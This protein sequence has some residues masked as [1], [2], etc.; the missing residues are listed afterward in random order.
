MIAGLGRWAETAGGAATLINLS[1][2]HTFRIDLPRGDRYILR[3]HRPGYQSPAAIDSELAWLAALR[4]T[5]LCRCRQPWP[6]A[7]AGSVQVL[8]DAGGA[9][10]V[11][12]CCLPSSRA[13]NRTRR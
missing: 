6:A 4:P 7:M 13:P 3:V 5:P 10:S 9:P 8:A 11:M 1:E 12:P 2:N